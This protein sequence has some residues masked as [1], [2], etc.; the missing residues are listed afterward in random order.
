VTSELP[1]RRRA[2]AFLLVAAL[3][4]LHEDSWGVAHDFD[5]PG[6]TIDV[7]VTLDTQP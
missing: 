7:A 6:K 4:E 3:T 5:A 1:T 2:A